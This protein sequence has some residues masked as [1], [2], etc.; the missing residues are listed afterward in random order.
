MKTRGIFAARGL[1]VPLFFSRCCAPRLSLFGAI[2]FRFP[3]GSALV[4]SSSAACSFFHRNV[5]Q[6][7]GTLRKS[8]SFLMLRIFSLIPLHFR[9]VKYLFRRFTVGHMILRVDI[10]AR[11]DLYSSR[12][13]A[14]FL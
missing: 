12:K 6:F 13:L 5:E 3:L 10:S 2:P 14:G 8:E 4:E 1:F 9:A 11:V 7:Q